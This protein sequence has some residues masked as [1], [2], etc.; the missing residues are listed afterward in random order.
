MGPRDEINALADAGN[1]LGI[2]FQVVDDLLDVVGDPEQTGKSIFGD[3]AQGK[4]T[5]LS[6][7]ISRKI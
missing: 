3:I 7:L 4:L 5:E 1:G 6:Y 2:A